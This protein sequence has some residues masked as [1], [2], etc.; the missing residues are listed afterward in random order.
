MNR[1]RLIRGIKITWTVV[2]GIAFMLIVALWV[3]SYW[4]VD[5]IWRVS[6]NSELVLQTAPGTFRMQCN[7]YVP[8][9]DELGWYY[10]AHEPVLQYQGFVWNPAEALFA[11]PIWFICVIFAVLATVPWVRWRFTLRTL[12]FAI[13]AVC[14]VLGLIV[15]AVR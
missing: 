10:Q 1:P 2:C 6:P 4:W 11:V 13:T 3:R 8:D 7:E 14:V 12:L 5:H 15:W 9:Q